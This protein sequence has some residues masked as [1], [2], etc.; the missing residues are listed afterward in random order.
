MLLNE[1]HLSNQHIEAVC[2]FLDS[3]FFLTE[4]SVLAYFT[5]KVSLPLLHSVQVS[6]L[7]LLKILPQLYTD[8][9]AGKMDTLNG[10]PTNNIPGECEFSVFDM[11]T[12]SAKCRNHKFKPKSICNDMTL[13]TSTFSNKPDTAVKKILKL[14]NAYEEDWGEKQKKLHKEKI[15]EKLKKGKDQALYTLKLLQQC[16]T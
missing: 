16:K 1:S 6:T 9:K 14:L 13:Y 11:K 12:N 10:L 15:V 7:E 8:L 5:H 2:L 3:E 4:L